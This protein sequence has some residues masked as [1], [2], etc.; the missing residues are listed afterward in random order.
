MSGNALVPVWCV[1]AVYIVRA[2]LHGSPVPSAISTATLV[3]HLYGLCHKPALLI[4]QDH[5][6]HHCRPLFQ[7]CPFCDSAE[8]ALSQRNCI[9]AC[10]AGVPTFNIVS[11]REVQFTEVSLMFRVTTTVQDW[12]VNNLILLTS[13]N[14]L[15]S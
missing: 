11:D 5:H 7:G 9:G 2:S 13:M 14:S 3:S 12:Y 8:V 4:W 10:E 15:S 6:P 1:C